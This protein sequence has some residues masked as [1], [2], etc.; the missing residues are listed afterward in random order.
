MPTFRPDPVVDPAVRGICREH[1]AKLGEVDG[2][3]TAVWRGYLQALAAAQAV[4]QVDGCDGDGSWTSNGTDREPEQSKAEWLFGKVLSGEADA[5]A[6]GTLSRAD[7][8]GDGADEPGGRAG[9]ADSSWRR[10]ATTMRSLSSSAM[11]ATWARIFRG[12]TNYV[13]RAEAAAGPVW[14]RD[15]TDDHSVHA[16]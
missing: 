6:A 10:C 16:G 13:Q 14:K 12:P 1:V 3:D 7:A 9:D 8:D 4:L 5:G 11:G 15:G 2:E